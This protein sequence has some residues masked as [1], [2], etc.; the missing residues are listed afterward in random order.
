MFEIF[1]GKAWMCLN[2]L[3]LLSFTLCVLRDAC[4]SSLEPVMSFISVPP[5]Q[6]LWY[7]FNVELS[8]IKYE[9][10]NLSLYEYLELDGSLYVFGMT[11]WK[12]KN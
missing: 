10:E 5:K 1:A 7:H 9:I 4:Y 11:L 3:H 12:A 6:W 2:M 8:L